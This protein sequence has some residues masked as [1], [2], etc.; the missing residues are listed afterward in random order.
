MLALYMYAANSKICNLNAPEFGIFQQ[1]PMWICLQKVIPEDTRNTLLLY[2][3]KNVCLL[4][5]LP[6]PL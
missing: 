1:S 4:I 2:G 6:H 5:S 3:N